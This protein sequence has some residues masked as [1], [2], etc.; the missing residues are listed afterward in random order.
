MA[1]QLSSGQ[2]LTALAGQLG[3]DDVERYLSGVALLDGKVILEVQN[4]FTVGFLSQPVRLAKIKSAVNSVGAHLK[5]EW[6]VAETPPKAVKR[7]QPVYLAKEL[8][9]RI[10]PIKRVIGSPPSD[11]YFE[12][13]P[14]IGANNNEAYSVLKELFSQ[15]TMLRRVLLYGPPGVGKTFLATAALADFLE[16]NPKSTAY[17][18]GARAFKA[19]FLDC[20]KEGASFSREESIFQRKITGANVLIMD[21]LHRLRPSPGTQE[22]L[23]DIIESAYASGK[24]CILISEVPPGSDRFPKL[25]TRLMS[26]VLDSAQPA[27]SYPSPDDAVKIAMQMLSFYATPG[28]Q[29]DPNLAKEI[30]VRVMKKSRQIDPRELS[31]LAQTAVYQT[32][33]TRTPTVR[34]LPEEQPIIPKEHDKISP[35]HL[36]NAVAGRY[37][38]APNQIVTETRGQKRYS[39]ARAVAA[40]LLLGSGLTTTETGRILGRN[41]T[42]I[43]AARDRVK[44]DPVLR[45]QADYLSQYLKTNSPGLRLQTASTQLELGL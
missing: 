8:A 42:T 24:P 38:M 29:V 44:T 36:I 28:M 11:K 21:D 37:G 22:V 2:V 40:Y 19:D 20:I 34:L 41:H 7:V 39:D 1:A 31:G 23:T 27:I 18:N 25:E 6:K 43:I 4:E 17:I 35:E 12:V 9:P 45:Q 30:V 14:V 13:D 5:L 15:G 33:I 26:R 10:P 16:A 3:Q 32:R